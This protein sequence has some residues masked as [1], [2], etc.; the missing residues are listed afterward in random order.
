MIHRFRSILQSYALYTSFE[1]TSA[2][3][4]FPNDRIQARLGSLCSV[5]YFLLN[6]GLEREAKTLSK[7]LITR[8]YCKLTL[9]EKQSVPI[10][11]VK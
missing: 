11:I 5:M 2:G 1:I 4:I 10:T 9:G 6:Y 7:V 3:V 8:S